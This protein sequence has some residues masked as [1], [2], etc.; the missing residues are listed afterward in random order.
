MRALLLALCL[1]VSSL[2]ACAQPAPQAGDVI[3]LEGRIVLKGNEPFVVAV[4]ESGDRQWDLR[5][6]TRQ[7][8]QALQSRTV[9]VTGTVARPAGEAGG[10]MPAQLQ[11]QSIR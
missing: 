7:Q 6:L 8:M 10:G 4:L 3:T 2:L 11:V 5:G 9:T 1:S